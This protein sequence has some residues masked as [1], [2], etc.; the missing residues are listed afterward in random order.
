MPHPVDQSDRP[1]NRFP[2]PLA[3]LGLLVLLGVGLVLTFWSPG[4]DHHETGSTP[5]PP[6][7]SHGAADTAP[8]P[9]PTPLAD[10]APT[11]GEDPV[12]AFAAWV[13]LLPDAPL[14]LGLKL[15][16]ERRPLI[17]TWIREDPVRALAAGL[18]P[19]ERAR[20]PAELHPLV[21][22]PR[23]GV[24]F[25]GVAALCQHEPA[26]GHA[27]TC[28]IEREVV[29]DF[30]TFTAEI[31]PASVYGAGLERL[32]TE[33]ASLYGLQLDGHIA[34]HEHETVAFPASRFTDDP[35]LADH[36]ALVH[37]GQVSFTPPAAHPAPP[38]Q[39]RP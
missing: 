24:G 36:V 30:G 28:R 35:A 19:Y 29:W 34:L 18:T 14:E 39:P 9:L 31:V 8:T 37:R 13:R 26:A 16:A 38:P 5:P 7:H 33:D 12:S 6:T 27:A 3:V 20:L 32:T 11:T 17:A 1:P 25:F 10:T 21:E 2:R 23:A 22:L 15:A 4:T